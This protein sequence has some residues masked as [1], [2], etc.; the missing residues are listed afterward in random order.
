MDCELIRWKDTIKEFLDPCCYKFATDICI[1][2]KAV[3]AELKPSYMFD[4]AFVSPQRIIPWL[5][6]LH[7]VHLIHCRLSVI[8]IEE[9][10][11]I[12]KRSAIKRRMS[13]IGRGNEQIIVADV[14]SDL[15]QPQSTSTT[16]CQ[17]IVQHYAKV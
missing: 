11:F 16:L 7:D 4:F 8:S 1:C 5:N 13:E 17:T 15:Q 6:Q 9:Q 10:I 14:S 2:V 3:D 12:V